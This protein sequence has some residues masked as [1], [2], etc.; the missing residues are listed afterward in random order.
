MKWITY[1]KLFK[2]KTTLGVPNFL[3][4]LLHKKKVTRIRIYKTIVI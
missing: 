3:G 1:E 4:D 2:E